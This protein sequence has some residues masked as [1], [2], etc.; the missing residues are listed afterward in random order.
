MFNVINGIGGGGLKNATIAKN[1]HVAL[2]TTFAIF[3]VFGGGF[4]NTPGGGMSSTWWLQL[5]TLCRFITLLQS[6]RKSN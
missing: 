6:S 2:Y 3:G 5:C 1:G 4:Y